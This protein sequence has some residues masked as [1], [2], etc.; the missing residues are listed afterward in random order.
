MEEDLKKMKVEEDLNLFHRKWKSW[1]NDEMNIISWG[2]VF[3]LQKKMRSTSINQQIEVVFHLNICMSPLLEPLS[4]GVTQGVWTPTSMNI[5][6]LSYLF[7]F[8]FKIKFIVNM[9]QSNLEAD[10]QKLIQNL[11]SSFCFISMSMPC[12][13][14]V[15]SLNSAKVKPVWC[16]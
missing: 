2:F 3:N 13:Q 4:T 14:P 9:Q 12:P 11:S 7:H 1:W 15:S 5:N 10:S 16:Q 8:I 6:F